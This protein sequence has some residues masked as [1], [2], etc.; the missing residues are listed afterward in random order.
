M[1]NQVES[2]TETITSAPAPKVD[3]SIKLV[4]RETA[5]EKKARKEAVCFSCYPN[6]TYTLLLL[7]AIN[8]LPF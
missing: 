1:S 2:D 8:L 6:I 3:T 7:L 4:K 5:A